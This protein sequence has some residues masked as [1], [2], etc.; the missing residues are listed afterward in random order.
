MKR[1]FLIAGLVIFSI[2]MIS[3]TPEIWGCFDL[4]IAGFLYFFSATPGKPFL[5]MMSIAKYLVMAG[6]VVVVLTII[7]STEARGDLQQRFGKFMFPKWGKWKKRRTYVQY[8]VLGLIVLHTALWQLGVIHLTCFC[9]L[10]ASELAAGGTYGL[11]ALFW[12]TVFVL[13][14]VL[15]RALCGWVC[16]YAPVMEQSINIL[17]AFGG[18]PVRIKYNLRF[19]LIHIIAAVFWVS[20]I[21]NAVKR[22]HYLSFNLNNGLP[23][24]DTWIFVVAIISFIPLTLLLTHLFGSRFFCKYVCPLGGTMSL[25]N[26]LALLRIRIDKEKCVDCGNCTKNCP[27]GVNIARFIGDDRTSVCDGS[28][29]VC[30]EC[31]DAC[32]KQALKLTF[33][34][35]WLALPQRID[36]GVSG[37]QVVFTPGVVQERGE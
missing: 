6:V 35:D 12:L 20:L 11:D 4:P 26:K 37:N 1:F 8:F 32:A 28:C 18:K 14:I 22:F 7:F 36:K 30:G 24:G 19:P 15:G 5:Y 34:N 2:G 10:T 17:S 33:R 21:F 25:Y 9:P 29:I 23:A 31:V 13:V 27:M 3:I 16:V